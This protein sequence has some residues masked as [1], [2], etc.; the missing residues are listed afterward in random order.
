[1]SG[2]ID[3]VGVGEVLYRGAECGGG[4]LRHAEGDMRACGARE[5]IAGIGEAMRGGSEES[6]GERRYAANMQTRRGYTLPSVSAACPS[7]GM[8]NPRFIPIS[9]IVC[10]S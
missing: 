2:G 3:G 1:M 5:G 7:N 10:I 9:L 6:A 4:G 8:S